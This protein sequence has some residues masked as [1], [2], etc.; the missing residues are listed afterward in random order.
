VTLTAERLTRRSI[1]RLSLVTPVPGAPQWAADVEQFLVVGAARQVLDRTGSALLVTDEDT[2]V[3]AAAHRPHPTFRA[4]LLQALLV[5][6]QHRRTGLAVAAL[7]CVLASI[8]A[9]GSEF[10]MW[11]V[12]EEN[13]PMRKVSLRVGATQ[14]GGVD[15]R[16]FV[17]Y[18]HP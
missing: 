3:A 10:V 2:V 12:H 5:L 16:G 14:I 17:A 1:H 15:E 18:A 6:P 11:L 8:R 4:E 13:S 7:E 9:D